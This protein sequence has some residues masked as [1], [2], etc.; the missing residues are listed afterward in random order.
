M[1]D[2]NIP[3]ENGPAGAA[4]RLDTSV[5]LQVNS[6]L[7]LQVKPFTPIDVAA[8]QEKMYKLA[9][10]QGQA[11][12]NQQDRAAK[13][14]TMA[15]QQKDEVVL[16]QYR[17]SGG[18][19]TTPEGIKK[20][21][22]ELKG[23]VSEATADRL[24]KLAD[25]K[26]AQSIKTQTE[27]A[28]LSDGIIDRL[29]A[30]AEQ[31]TQ[32]LSRA[33]SVYDQT[34]AQTKDPAKALAAFNASKQALA[35]D[36]A[37]VKDPVTGRSA[38]SP[39]QIKR[40]ASLDPEALRAEVQE[41][42]YKQKQLNDESKRRLQDAQA[43]HLGT[44]SDTAVGLLDLKQQGLAL[45]EKE[46]DQKADL[47]RRKLDQGSS[48]DQNDLNSAAEM[49]RQYGL[50]V[51]SRLGLPPADRKAVL[52]AVSELNDA[53]GVSAKEGAAQIALNRGN[54]S[55]L[56]KLTSQLDKITAYN[57]TTAQVGD[58][59]V[60][61]A[62]KVDASGVPVIDR[63]IRAGRQAIAGDPDVTEFNSRLQTFTT[64]SALILNSA[65]LNG[66]TTDSARHEMQ[67]IL[68]RASSVAQIERGVH[69]MKQET[70]WREKALQEQIDAAKG[71]MVQ[72]AQK[73]DTDAP[74][75]KGTYKQVGIYKTPDE[76]KAAYQAHTINKEE[77]R[78]LLT[79]MGFGNG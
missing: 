16:G 71:R 64:E 65:N 40:I 60:D 8:D 25:A 52:H 63:W 35:T 28:K 5:P 27:L 31:A 17:Q 54:Q 57:K 22:S 55:S 2:Y 23:N 69:V 68:P 78:T 62:K 4:A 42:S 43:E 77:A 10:L 59:L 56:E 15:A 66:A 34:L 19:L 75:A 32:F 26:E 13:Q 58:A 36:A 74:A 14:Q 37:N 50:Q 53:E 29:H 7:P 79:Q 41:T 70:Q 6:T 9:D 21:L 18:D 61:V 45:H 76:I 12:E 20:A 38:Y 1:P 67:D 11:A 46:I 44:L 33:L 3:M 73:K 48:L 47:L 72:G 24:S 39:D 49:V 30:S 51:M